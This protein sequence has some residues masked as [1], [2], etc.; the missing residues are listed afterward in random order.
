M[1]KNSVPHI[2]WDKIDF[3]HDDIADILEQE[4][5][6]RMFRRGR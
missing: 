2:D 4:R 5:Q 3:E 1:I 6:D